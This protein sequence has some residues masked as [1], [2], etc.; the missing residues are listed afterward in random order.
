MR[1]VILAGGKGSR[2]RPFTF[3][4]PKPLVPVA[5]MPILEILI[6]QLKHQGFDRLTV[7]VG[8]LAPIIRAFCGDGW[9]WGIPIDYVTEEQPLGT[10]GCVALLE[11]LAE[12]DRL[13]VINGDILTDM[14][15]AKAYATHDVK[16]AVTICANQR[17]VDVDFGVLDTDGNG[18]LARYTE[19]PTLHYRVSMGVNVVST[20]TVKRYIRGGECLDT[21]DLVRRLQTAGEGVRVLD[22]DAYWLDIGR[23]ND[24]EAG[25]EV[26]RATPHRFLP[27]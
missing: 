25:N 15:M 13:L 20:W 8:Y 14:D 11:D 2:L 17:S 5:E 12:A 1:A 24:L 19:K 9:R 27:G 26:F 6:R 3:A 4:I 10:I 22:V 21:P 18:Y 23:A 7:S 16:D